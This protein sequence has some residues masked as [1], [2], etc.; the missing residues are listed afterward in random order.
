MPV[1]KNPYSVNYSKYNTIG[2]TVRK[3]NT[4][5]YSRTIF[6]ALEPNSTISSV[7]ILTQEC[8]F[9]PNAQ[10]IMSTIWLLNFLPNDAL[11]YF[12]ILKN[13]SFDYWTVNSVYWIF[14]L[15]AKRISCLVI[16]IPTFLILNFEIV[17]WI[18]THE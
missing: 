3:F 6:S 12:L 18:F 1:G 9:G 10:K 15:I 4:Q 8:Y 5:Y 17:N 2:D 7:L 11:V 16:L 14:F 13:I